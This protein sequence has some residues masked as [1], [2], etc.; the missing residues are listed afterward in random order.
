[1]PE[2]PEITNLALQMQAALVGRRIAAV[3]VLQAKSLNLSEDEFSAAV[4]GAE[5][6]RAEHHGKWLKVQLDRGWLLLNLGMGGEVLLVAPDALPEKHRLVFGLA[7][8]QVLA[9]NFWWVGYAHYVAPDGLAGHE[10][11]ARLGPE[12]ITLSADDL[13]ALF[14]RR[15]GG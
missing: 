14:A 12:A 9:I 4:V 10:M 2:L 6:M 15:R 5:I 7:D 8:G 1:M 3:E 11:T 13:R